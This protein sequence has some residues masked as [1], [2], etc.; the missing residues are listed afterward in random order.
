MSDTVAAIMAFSLRKA[1]ATFT[2]HYQG[3]L[4]IRHFSMLSLLEVGLEI[5]QQVSQVHVVTTCL[6][7]YSLLACLANSK[8]PSP[9]Y[10]V[11][12]LSI[13]RNLQGFPKRQVY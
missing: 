12:L 3:S 6:L 4:P 8:D 13:N 2:Q 9:I 7:D 11:S 1:T 10:L 5:H